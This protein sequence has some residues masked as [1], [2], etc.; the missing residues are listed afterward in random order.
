M[1]VFVRIVAAFACL[2]LLGLV[3][4]LAPPHW[5]IRR[6]APPLPGAAELRVL[7]AEP[8][9][10]IAVEFLVTAS[11]ASPLGVLGHLVFV[12]RWADGRAF[13]IDA[14]MDRAEA[15][16]FAELLKLIWGADDGRF[17]GDV[18]ELLGDDLRQV[19]GVGFTHL[20]IDHS[21]GVVPFCAA[22][23]NVVARSDAL[24]GA[25]DLARDESAA[26][27]ENVFV[28]QTRWQAE[29]HN[30]NT[31]EGAS[32]VEASCLEPRTLSG[33]GVMRIDGFPGLGVVALGGHTPGST[34]FAVPVAGHLWLFSGDVTNTK[35][36]LLAD[37]GKPFYYSHL[38]V[39]EN[40]ARTAELRQWLAAL[41]ARTDTTVIVSHDLPDIEASGLPESALSASRRHP[42]RR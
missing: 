13:M 26:R 20:H 3:I 6:I 24:A 28:Y 34:L 23:G 29:E 37:V 19:R 4:L 8:D 11:Q 35:A 40:T 16:E 36:A 17:H 30:F 42:R 5:Q 39:P 21:Q 10:P 22:R 2:L 33:D 38:A 12:V 9:G 14:G 25:E 31:T 32:L 27:V 7:A 18:A 15:A 41:D 1:R